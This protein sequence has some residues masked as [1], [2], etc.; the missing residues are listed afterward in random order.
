[1]PV[2]A[3]G[4]LEAR[5]IKLKESFFKKMIHIKIVYIEGGARTQQRKRKFGSI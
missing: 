2:I 5:T 4:T 1:M 3:M